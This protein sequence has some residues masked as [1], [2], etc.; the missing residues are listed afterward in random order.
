MTRVRSRKKIINEAEHYEDLIGK[1]VVKA[2]RIGV[3]AKK[4]K[5]G[6]HV[7]TVKGIIDHPILH[8]PAYTFLEDDSYVACKYCVEL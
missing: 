6:R 3:K 7:N 4:F 2:H 8:V 1:C 5:S